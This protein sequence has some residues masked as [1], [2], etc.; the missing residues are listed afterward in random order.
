L[1]LAIAACSNNDHSSMPASSTGSTTAAPARGKLIQSP[2]QRVGSY[3]PSELLALLAGS[4]LGKTLLQLAYTPMCTIDVYHLEYDTVDPLGNLTPASG[5]LMVPSG[6]ASCQGGRPVLLYAHA[7]QTNRAYDISALAASGNDEGLLMA[8]VFAAEGYIVV[9]P[10]YVGYDISTLGYH[11][12]LVAQQQS[13]DMIDALA[14][15]R[16]ALP[17]A[18]AASTT[19]GGKLFVT[20]YSQGGYV[21]MATL[22]AMQAAQM[23]VTA[24]APMSGPY[25]LSAY[26]D[27][28]FEGEVSLSAPENLI[29]LAAGYQN[30]YKNLYS[31]TTDV[32]NPAYA[33]GIGS[34]LPSDTAVSTLESQG[35]IPG[36]LFSATPPAPAYAAMTPATVPQNLA[37]AFALGFGP[38]YLVTNAYRLAYLQD[39][40][41][42]PDGGFPG[43]TDRLPPANP[44]NGLRVD[45]KTNDLR[46]FEPT[47]PVLLCAGSSDP[48]V[49]YLN[50]QLMVDYWTANAAAAHLTVLDIDSPVAANDPYASLKNGF[51]AAKA[52][53]IA[54]AVAGGA[55]DGGVLQVLED[56]HA[57][58][59]PPFC[60]SA[61]KA[62]F[63]ALT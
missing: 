42:A 1:L 13:A 46:T 18:D 25:A 27:A 31:V 38:D 59:V 51:V 30:I 8:A 61:A 3:S 58:L 12:Y 62:F 5:A 7:T 10:N 41:A 17:T 55:T 15:G 48:T 24:A 52:L 33:T 36:A 49:F 9:A 56:Y 57:T 21:A 63:D 28:V 44:K 43:V 50:T 14:A 29:M 20:G 22:R 4:A 2:V 45:L 16:S 6:A 39:A 37:P 35:K 19:D 40:A 32:F 34:L 26:V 47:G 23:P 11:P 53:V 54:G 60:L